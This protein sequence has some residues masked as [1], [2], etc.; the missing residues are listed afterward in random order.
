MIYHRGFPGGLSSRR[1]L[2]VD[3]QEEDLIRRQELRSGD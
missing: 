2:E 1:I 3:K